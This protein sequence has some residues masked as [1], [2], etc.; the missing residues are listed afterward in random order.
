MLI[1]SR[2]V[3]AHKCC[4]SRARFG[5]RALSPEA[6]LAKEEEKRRDC[7]SDRLTKDQTGS[8]SFTPWLQQN[9]S[10]KPRQTEENKK[11]SGERTK[12]QTAESVGNQPA[13]A[14]KRE[15]PTWPG[16][17]GHMEDRGGRRPLPPYVPALSSSVN[18]PHLRRRGQIPRDLSST[19]T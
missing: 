1:D 2:L 14:N 13:S 4:G 19:S 15:R 16:W 7:H 17:R 5:I 18:R 10:A 3:S 11:K 8:R 6:R 12:A 9:I